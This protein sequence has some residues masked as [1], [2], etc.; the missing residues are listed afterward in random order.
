MVS[1]V[2]VTI[3]TQPHPVCLHLLLLLRHSHPACF[4]PQSLCYDVIALLVRIIHGKHQPLGDALEITNAAEREPGNEVIG[5]DNARDEWP[6]EF[7]K[8][9]GGHAAE[10]GLLVSY[11]SK[12]S[13]APDARDGKAEGM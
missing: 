1:N 9:G 8:G 12:W 6:A 5:I 4:D 3:V 2:R 10:S 13:I 11:C 7:G